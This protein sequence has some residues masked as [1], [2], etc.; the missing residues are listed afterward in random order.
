ML[1][2]TA[3]VKI[4]GKPVVMGNL[5][6]THCLALPLVTLYPLGFGYPEFV[7]WPLNFPPSRG[8]CRAFCL[9]HFPC[10]SVLTAFSSVNGIYLS[11][12]QGEGHPVHHPS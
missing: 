6:L 3:A 8:P 9:G 2:A 1:V 12:S 7:F 5:S 11:P 10:P 4:Q